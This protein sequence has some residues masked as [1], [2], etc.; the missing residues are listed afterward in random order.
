MQF[1]D[2]DKSLRDI[3]C[4]IKC[5]EHILL[6]LESISLGTYGSREGECTFLYKIKKVRHFH[7][8]NRIYSGGGQD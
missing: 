1:E 8:I 7:K 3:I 4:S 5:P 2:I 6:D